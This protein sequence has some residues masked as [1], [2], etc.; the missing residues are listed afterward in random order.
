MRSK[1][2]GP[3]G[4][5]R[6]LDARDD[7][8]GCGP[9]GPT[10]NTTPT[11]ASSVQA[12]GGE[13]SA[14]RA[15]TSDQDRATR[16][17]RRRGRRRWPPGRSGHHPG[18][19]TCGR[20][21]RATPQDH[22]Q[23]HE[24]AEPHGGGHG[25]NDRRAHREELVVGAAGVTVKANEPAASSTAA[26]IPPGASH[27]A[28]AA[29]SRAGRGTWPGRP[30]LQDLAQHAVMGDGAEALAVP[31]AA[32]IGVRPGSPRPDDRRAAD[33]AAQSVLLGPAAG[34][35]ARKKAPPA[36]SNTP[37]TPGAEDSAGDLPGPVRASSKNG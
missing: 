33:E 32:W 31:S 10:T 22:G 13:V 14:R 37:R 29:P 35:K 25:V 34:T 20:P 1:R 11:L 16:R 18:R 6:A 8:N 30:L 4:R 36:A 26:P 19:A 5:R 17:Q 3:G 27:R 9:G 28:R 2:P 24:A 7:R 23:Q 15:R 21:R 12:V